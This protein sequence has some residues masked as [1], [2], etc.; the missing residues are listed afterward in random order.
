MFLKLTP[1]CDKHGP[2][3]AG[4]LIKKVGL[5]LLGGKTQVFD[6]F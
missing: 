6:I 1:L 4:T 2:I 5:P 3:P